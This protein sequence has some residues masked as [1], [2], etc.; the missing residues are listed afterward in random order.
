MFKINH[1]LVGNIKGGDVSTGQ[2]ITPYVGSKPPN[3]S[4]L[5]RYIFLI[6]EQKCKLKFEELNDPEAQSKRLSFS[7]RRFAKKYDL[8][9][10]FAG[11]YYHAQWEPYVDTVRK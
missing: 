8:G 11:N 10:A 3:G 7:I 2:V 4:G 6:Y 1:W 9:K 5:H